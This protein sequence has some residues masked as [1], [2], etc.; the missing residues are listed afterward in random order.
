[1]F[2]VLVADETGQEITGPN[3]AMA[4]ALVFFLALH[5]YNRRLQT[6]PC[7]LFTNVGGN[8]GAAGSKWTNNLQAQYRSAAARLA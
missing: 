2:F 8:A 6:G 7:K 4:G 5:H 1:M 3:P